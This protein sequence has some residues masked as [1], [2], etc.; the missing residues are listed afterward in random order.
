MEQNKKSAINI[1]Q[2]YSTLALI[3]GRKNNVRVNVSVKQAAAH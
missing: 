2:L 1:E 3:I